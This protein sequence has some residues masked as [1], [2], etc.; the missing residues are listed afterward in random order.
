[1]LVINNINL[2][3]EVPLQNTDSTLP[4]YR[5]DK[6]CLVI[7]INKN[8]EGVL[9]NLGTPFNLVIDSKT[10]IYNDIRIT[11]TMIGDNHVFILKL[12]N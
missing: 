11:P 2:S 9:N 4:R 6:D 3:E 5:F 8:E 7:H 1:M 12:S 10:Y